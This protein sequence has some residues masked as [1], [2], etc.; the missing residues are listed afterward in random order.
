PPLPIERLATRTRLTPLDGGR[1]RVD[2]SVDMAPRNVVGAV[3]GRLIVGQQMLRD[4]R[5]A[6][7]T[8][9][10]LAVAAGEVPPPPARSPAVNAARLAQGGRALREYGMRPALVERL[11]AH[12]RAAGDPDVVRM[13]PFALADRWG[14][15][16]LDVL[17]L[18]LYATRAGLLDLEWD[19]LCPNCRGP[20]VRARTLADLTGEA[21]CN[22]CNIR[23]DLNFDES[24]ELRF[25]VSPTVREA[26][27]LSYCIGGPANTRHI[28]AQLWLPARGAKELRL[29]LPAGSYRIRSRQLPAYALLEVEEG[30]RA[31]EARVRF[32]PHDIVAEV[33]ALAAG[34]AALALVNETDSGLLVVIEQTAWSAQAASAA[35]VTALS[36]FRQLFSAEVLAPGLGIAIR[37]LT[38]LFSDLKDS[39]RIY[40]T[41]G[42][43]PAYARV[44]D[45]FD[46]MRRIIGEHRGALVKTIGDAV[47][48]VF[49]AAD[50][51]VRAAL[52]IQR[53]FTAGE[54][55]R[56]NPAL[57]VKLG[58]HRGPCIAVNANDLLDYFGSTVN[59]AARV[60]GESVGGDIVVTEAVM[61]D[62]EVQAVL[63]R[64]SPAVE[65]FHRDLKGISQSPTLYR[66]WVS[67]GAVAPVGAAGA[68]GVQGS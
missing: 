68:L 54:I 38:F 52:A 40:D 3:G 31:R 60:Q 28:L 32:A 34:A 49:P 6:Y 43:S 9:G 62:P 51:G 8:L 67:Q 10:A 20:S 26:L 65:T 63:A 56:G 61:G 24:V 22:S 5:R 66:L 64:E 13:R 35:L 4:L 23:Y 41:I 16:R 21:H 25:S 46:L 57:R 1:T 59:I 33:P 27:D 30:H 44:R 18:F 19:V 2:V 11:V 36:E 15:P 48:A 55:A 14:E 50:D 29:R 42:D 12:L 17:R 39:T 37:T 58:L 45:H 53:A 47:M 7:Q